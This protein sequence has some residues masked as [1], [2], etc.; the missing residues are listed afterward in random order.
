MVIFAVTFA[1]AQSQ[2]NRVLKHDILYHLMRH[3]YDSRILPIRSPRQRQEQ[4]VIRTELKAN[5]V[6]HG[7]KCQET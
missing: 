7:N 4:C 2:H 6:L 5:E 1:L 3:Q